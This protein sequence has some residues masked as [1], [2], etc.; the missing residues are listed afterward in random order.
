MYLLI[1]LFIEFPALFFLV[2]SGFDKWIGGYRMLHSA[3]SIS[4]LC[5]PTV[6]PNNSL[7]CVAWTSLSWDNF[8]SFSIKEGTRHLSWG[9]A[10]FSFVYLLSFCL[11]RNNVSQNPKNTPPRHRHVWISI[12]ALITNR[13]FKNLK[14]SKIVK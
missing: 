10:D 1:D 6:N 11:Q 2:R 9:S 3:V 8:G 14:K 13:K 5:L 12:Y 4:L 7:L